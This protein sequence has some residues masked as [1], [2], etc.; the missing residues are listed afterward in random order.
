[1]DQLSPEQRQ[2]VAE[3]LRPSQ[4]VTDEVWLTVVRAFEWVLWVATAALVAGVG[5]ALFRQVDQALIQ[6]LLTV[7]TTVVGVFAGF[8]SGKALGGSAPPAGRS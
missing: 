1:M 3:W 4:A 7:F 5:I 8:I 2:E 6:I